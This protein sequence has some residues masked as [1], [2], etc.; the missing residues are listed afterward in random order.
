MAKIPCKGINK[1]GTP[2]KGNGL[3]A[4]DG[5]CIAHGPAEKTREWRVRGGKNS[6]TAARADQRTP[7]RLRRAFEELEQGLV[8]VREGNLAPAAYTAMSRGVM[9]MLAL[10]RRSDEEMDLIRNEETE[11][12]A[13][14]VLG[15]H[16]DLAILNA[17][18]QIAEQQ[19][20]H[21]IESLIA[22]GLATLEQS[23][24][25]GEP[26]EPVLTDKGRRRFGYQRLTGYTQ[27]DLD[28]LKYLLL[29]RSLSGH[30][31]AEM[32]DALARMRA[33]MEEAL[34]DLAGNPEPPR[35]PLT[36]QPLTQLPAGVK[37][38]PLTTDD[39]DN[40]EQAAKVLKDQIR[41]TNKLTLD[42]KDCYEYEDE[43]LDETLDRLTA[44]PH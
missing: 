11:T 24:D 16:G 30:Q 8:D 18:A 38:G 14:E 7:E 9:A 13:M 41:Q 2:C 21:R 44:N 42:F 34:A 17:A 36:G 32:R 43:L 12:A 35:D 22:Q 39:T 33:A 15:D 10:H 31:I 27:E 37:I 1:D 6:S 29:E 5:Y 28:H 3:P 25:A 19:N 40:N 4:L 20:Q 23:Q 26:A